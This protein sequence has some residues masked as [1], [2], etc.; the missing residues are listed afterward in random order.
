MS[1]KV[2]NHES[3][4]GERELPTDAFHKDKHAS[5]GL[6]HMCKECA[7][8]K[9]RVWRSTRALDPVWRERFN[10]NNKKYRAAGGKKHQMFF[11]AMERARKKGIEFTITKEDIV[12]PEYCPILGIKLEAG[13][14]RKRDSDSPSLVGAK[15][16][17]PSLDRIDNS[18]GYI[19]GNVLVISWRAN[20]L[21]NTA[22]LDELV[23]L[24]EFAKQ[25][26]TSNRV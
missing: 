19:P 17:S 1:T 18:K 12:I 25:Y 13:L 23:M 8:R 6:K 2:C 7:R 11:A 15:D 9:A 20:Y 26:T 22:T 5:D 14:G 10:E 21:K 4:E 24:G 3:H 16:S